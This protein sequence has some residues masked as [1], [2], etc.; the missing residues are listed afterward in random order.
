MQLARP[1]M[2]EICSRWIEERLLSPESTI[3]AYWDSRSRKDRSGVVATLASD[4]GQ[5]FKDES[6]MDLPADIKTVEV[7]WI[8]SLVG[9]EDAANVAYEIKLSSPTGQVKR[10]AF[11]DT[12]VVDR[13]GWR[14]R[15]RRSGLN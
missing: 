1:A 3:V 6:L 11:T 15:E 7:D 8:V 13:G 4:A 2:G 14:L 12:L 9:N 5:R 10:V